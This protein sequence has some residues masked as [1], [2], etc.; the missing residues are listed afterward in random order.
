MFENS[1]LCRVVRKVEENITIILILFLCFVPAFV[2]AQGNECVDIVSDVSRLEC[3][4]NAFSLREA[5][6]VSPEATVET[7]IE[8]VNYEGPFASLEL[9]RGED[10]CA[11]R[12]VLRYF[13][14]PVGIAMGSQQ[15]LVS[16]VNLASVERVGKWGQPQDGHYPIVLYSE[17]G[18]SGSWVFRRTGLREVIAGPGEIVEASVPVFDQYTGRD[19]RFYLAVQEFAPDLPLIRSAL[20]AAVAACRSQ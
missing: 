16:N 19:A 8:L 3:F 5:D 7:L 13:N 6:V 1:V 14:N 2:K 17:R 9:S 10:P 18:T 15:V 20:E 11:L 4:D 12:T